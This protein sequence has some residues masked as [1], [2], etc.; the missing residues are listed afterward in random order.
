MGTSPL[1]ALAPAVPVTL[2]PEVAT[3]LLADRD[4]SLLAGLSAAAAA[5]AALWDGISAGPVYFTMKR[6][7]GTS[8]NGVSPKNSAIIGMMRLYVI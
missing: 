6:S 5:A 2:V 4:V 3:V 7:S 1:A 8:L